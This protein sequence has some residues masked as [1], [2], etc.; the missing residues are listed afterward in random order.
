MTAATSVI[1]SAA[2]A[3]TS[4]ATWSR[5]VINGKREPHELPSRASELG[6]VEPRQP[7]STL[8]ATA[9]QRLVS[10]GAPGPA[11]PSPPTRGGDVRVTGE[12]V[13]HHHHVVAGGRQ[14][15]PSLHRDRDVV[16]LGAVL[17]GQRADVDDADLTLGG[18]GQCAARRR[19]S[20]R[21]P[22][23]GRHG[24]RVRSGASVGASERLAAAK[25]RSRSARMSSIPSRPDGQP[26]QARRHTG[27]QLLLGGR[28]AGVGGRGRMDHQRAH[29]TDVGHVA[30][31]LERVDQSPCPPRRHR[32]ARRTT[33]HRFPWAPA[34]SPCSCHGELGSPA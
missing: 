21:A 32:Q 23:K 18:Q 15:A 9:H 6:P 25:P 28:A 14:L 12:R 16:E 8:V 11:I 29:V 22:S 1:P 33:P 4:A 2:S 17:E 3:A 10:I 20:R 30:V 24:P 31:Q 7:P 5:T 19:V 34:S 26:D 13:Q 27:G